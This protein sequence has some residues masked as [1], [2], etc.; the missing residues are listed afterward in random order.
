MQVD[1][2]FGMEVRRGVEGGL[3]GA[4]CDLGWNI[5]WGVPDDYRPEYKE[6]MARANRPTSLHRASRAVEE[7]HGHY[8]Q[9]LPLP[10]PIYNH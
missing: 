7:C 4:L 1:D 2:G 5:Q 6:H 3:I 10:Q 8:V 9:P